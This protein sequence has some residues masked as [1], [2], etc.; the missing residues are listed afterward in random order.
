M[1]PIW[2]NLTENYLPWLRI[3]PRPFQ[4]VSVLNCCLKDAELGD[5]PGEQLSDEPGEQLSDEPGEQLSDEPGEESG[6]EL[7]LLMLDPRTPSVGI[8][9]VLDYAIRSILLVTSTS[10]DML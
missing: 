5:E 9:T 7:E 1:H 3:E 6:E 4:V 10:G 8:T 2:T